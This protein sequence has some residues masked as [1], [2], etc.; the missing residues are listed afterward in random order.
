MAIS[1]EADL[2]FLI[3]VYQ[4][5]NVFRH[6]L[7]YKKS[8]GKGRYYQKYDRFTLAQRLPFI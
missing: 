1:P 2:D 5:N 3:L 8:G 7:V 4:T 6:I